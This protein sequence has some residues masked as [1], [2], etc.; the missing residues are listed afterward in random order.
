MITYPYLPDFNNG[1][2]K[3]LQKLGHKWI[4]PYMEPLMKLLIL[5]LIWVNLCGWLQ[6]NDVTQT[7]RDKYIDMM[8]RYDLCICTIWVRYLVGYPISNFIWHTNGKYVYILRSVFLF[9]RLKFVMYCAKG[10]ILKQ[11][12]ECNPFQIGPNMEAVSI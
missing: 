10:L 7:P 3:Q 4:T 1:L 6:M 2:I 11:W 8:S 12:I 5:A 9:L